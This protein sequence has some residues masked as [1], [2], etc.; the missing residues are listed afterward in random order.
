MGHERIP[1]KDA[2]RVYDKET[3]ANLKSYQGSQLLQRRLLVTET[4]QTVPAYVSDNRWVANCP[5]CNGGFAVSHQ[6]PDGICLDCGSAYAVDWSADTP[7]VRQALRARAPRLRHFF[8]T[9]EIAQ[10]HGRLQADTVTSLQA[11]NELFGLDHHSWTSPRTWVTG[12]MVTS[13][14]MNTH[15]RDNLNETGPALVT[16]AEDLLVAT[17][18]NDLKRLA[19]G[20]DGQVLT[21]V[22]GAV[23]W[24]T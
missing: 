20:T 17:A 7:E 18:A 23:A 21:M 15:L 19:K 13:S 9:D 8:P 22:S 10:S 16:T 1:I 5:A 14:I 11:E 24:A 4:G 2:L 6:L 3:P 12:E